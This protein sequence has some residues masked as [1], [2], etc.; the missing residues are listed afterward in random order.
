MKQ[1]EH[2]SGPGIV[3]G[4]PTLGR[5]VPLD[6]AFSFKG[7]NP[8]INFNQIL[9]VVKGSEIGVARQAIAELAVEKNAKYLFFLGDDVVVPAHTLRWLIYRMEQDPKIGC[10][11]G[12]YC[13][14]AD[15]A[16]PLVFREN[17]RGSY[18][19]WKI[20]EFFEV[21]GLGMDCTLIRVDALKDLPKPWFKTHDSDEFL[22]GKNNAEQ[23]TEDLYF[24]KNLLTNSEYKIYADAGVMCEHW[25]V[26]GNKKYTL[27]TDSLPMRQRIMDPNKKKCLMIGSRIELNTDYDTVYF[28]GEGGD[29]RGQM[30]SLPFANESFDHIIVTEPEQIA[31]TNDLFNT[32]LIEWLRVRKPGGIVSI[33]FPQF[34]SHESICKY[35]IEK[36]YNASINGTFVE[37]K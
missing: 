13:A 36:Q 37:I 33:N 18:W 24:C 29:Y 3:I 14:K 19:D 16:Y 32:Y 9:Q 34:Y 21:T 2:N 30:G 22:D 7:L 28:G 8:P 20:G 23:W 26:Y 11:G 25:D 31:V 12:I 15:P 35:L 1:V 6:W 27:P 17:G 5:P 4:I 10:V